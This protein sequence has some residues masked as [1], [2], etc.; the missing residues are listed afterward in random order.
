MVGVQRRKAAMIPACLPD[1]GGRRAWLATGR[2]SH[3]L[4]EY[5]SRRLES[6]MH[7]DDVEV[8]EGDDSRS[9]VTRSGKQWVAMLTFWPRVIRCF[10]FLASPSRRQEF[11]L[12]WPLSHLPYGGRRGEFYRTRIASYAAEDGELIGWFP[13][14][15]EEVPRFAALANQHSIVILVSAAFSS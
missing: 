4:R 13:S 12:R 6:R 2:S 9:K 8:A 10:C 15:L 3:I 7:A 14:A 5:V 1:P 11:A